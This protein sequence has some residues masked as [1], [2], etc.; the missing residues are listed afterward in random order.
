MISEGSNDTEDWSN[1]WLI[2]SIA[3]ISYILKYIKTRKPILQ[4]A[5]IFHN[6]TVFFCIF[7]QI[8]TALMCMRDSIK[9]H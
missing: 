2:F 5:V 8:N 9:K 3:E 4:I 6:I 1:G 7:D